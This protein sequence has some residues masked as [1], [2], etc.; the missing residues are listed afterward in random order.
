MKTNANGNVELYDWQVSNLISSMDFNIKMLEKHT[1]LHPT[2][3][4]IV[5]YAKQ[6]LNT[7]KKACGIP[8]NLTDP[9]TQTKIEEAYNNSL[10]S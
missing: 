3:R 9:E 8:V 4:H 7:F 5:G 2:I 1:E 6:D 10:K